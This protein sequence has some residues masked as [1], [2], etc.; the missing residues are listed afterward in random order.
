MI[1]LIVILTLCLLSVSSVSFA[2][3]PAPVSQTGQT[4]CWDS[5]GAVIS[6]AGT[7]Q[8]GE[9]RAGVA[10]PI[11]RFTDNSN[12]TITDNLTGLIWLKLT[13]C[14]T[15]Q[16]S[17][18]YMAISNVNA[19]QS[20]QC[21]LTDNSVAGQWRLP[22]RNELDSLLVNSQETQSG[23]WLNSQGFINAHAGSYL[24]TSSTLAF[25][26]NSAW[27]IDHSGEIPN[28]G[29]KTYNGSHTWAV[30]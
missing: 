27:R 18:W 26:T 14:A 3:P 30:R 4:T 10:W 29:I 13:N 25:L 15:I 9:R 23:N 21:G 22:N 24:W 7:G 12:G 1:R 20:G 19:L 6:C 28:Y 11:P 2:T 17:S 16:A 5:A 8:D